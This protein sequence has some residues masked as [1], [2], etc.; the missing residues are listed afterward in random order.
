M[1]W[2][3]LSAAVST[4]LLLTAGAMAPVSAQSPARGTSAAGSA[5]AGPATTVRL[6]TGDRVTVGTGPDGRRTASVEPAP[7]REGIIFKTAEED[8]DLSVLPSDAIGPVSTGKLD[9]RL[10]DVT[11]LLAQGYDEAHTDA[12]PLI[13]SQPAGEPASALDRLSALNEDSA[14]SH[15][16]DSIHA[17]SLRIDGDDLNSFWKQLVPGPDSSTAR[18]AATPKVWLDGRVSPTLDRSTA[19]INAPA[20]WNAGYEGQGVKVAILDT[21]ADLT[22]PDLAGRAATTK[23]FSGSAGTNDAF[24]HGTHVASTVGGSGAASDGRRRGVAPR[25]ELLIGKVL[26]DDGY[27]SESAVIQGMEWAAAEGARVIN[28]SLGSDTPT[29]GTDP[30]SLAVNG[31]SKSS[32]AL[33]VVAAGNSGEQGGE[34]IGSPGAADAALTVGAVDRDDSLAPFSSRGPRLG[35]GAVKPDVTAPG[36]GIVAAR[37]TGTTMGDPVDPYYVAASGTS[38]ATPHVAGAAALL[39]QEHPDW[40]AVRLKDALVSTAHT[41]PGQQVT[42]QGGGRV[43]LAAAALGP[44]TATGTVSLGSYVSG[45]TGGKGQDATIRYTNTSSSEV[46]LRLAARLATTGGQEIADGGVRLGADSVRVAAGATAEVPLHADPSVVARGKYYGYVSATTADGKVAVHT[47]A[48]LTVHG[49]THRLTVNTVD[50]NGKRLQGLPTIWGPDG[51]VNYVSETPAVAEVEEGTY[52]LSY[53]SL[54]NAAD[55]QELREV[56][57]PEVKVTKDMAVTLDARKTT[58]VEIRTPKPAEQRGVLSYQTYRQLDGHGLIQ[59]TMFFDVAKRLYISPTAKVTEG[60]FEFASRWQLVAPLLEAK[61]PGTKISLSPYY[62]HVSPLFGDKGARLSPVDAGTSAAPD[63]RGSRVR[64]K[65]AVVRDE[66]SDETDLAR[67]AARAGAAGLVL[68]FPSDMYSWTRWSPL[69]DRLALPTMRVTAAEGTAL[70]ERAER[71]KTTVEFSGTA[72]SPYLYDVMQVSAGQVPQHVVHTVSDRNSAVVP[73]TYAASGDTGWGSE[74]RFARRPYQDFVWNQYSRYVPTGT[75]RT[76]YVSADDTLWQ[77]FVSDQPAFDVDVPLT[78]GMRD[79]ERT[80]R[81]GKQPGDHWFGAVVRPAI[82]RGST[83]PSVRTGDV[84]ALRIPELTDSGS[85]HWGRALSGGGG[86]GTSATPA[87]E[88]GNAVSARL[89]RNG[90]KTA[91]APDAWAD[92]E[93]A[94][95]K[96]DYRLDLSTSRDAADWTFGT[97][98]ETSWSFRSDTAAGETIL[99]LLQ[100]DYDVPADEHNT[101]TARRGHELGLTVRG[102]DGLS[103]PRGV[104]VQVET[105]YDNG[106]TWT[107]EVRAKD[108]GQNR[109]TTT[110]E[111]P[112]R[113]RGDIYVTLRVTAADSAGNKI[114]QTVERAYLL[115]E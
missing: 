100:L 11:E 24:G 110:V 28:M 45:D 23:D 42:E 55:G 36:V 101:V 25:A 80:Y 78:Q 56:V 76:E 111:R 26:G 44:V 68:I 30:M 19:Q 18:A 81:P 41:V 12:L 108:R 99:P 102:Q 86:I 87:A 37:A 2:T 35:D 74:Q 67:A 92:F 51:F 94:P 57:L 84:L 93:V 72:E 60:Q 29:D 8:G 73:T 85:G 61:V 32:G 115:S 50:H 46:T 64:G 66:G 49:P 90:K 22:H 21:G 34:T 31:L 106:K 103:A 17:R 15:R 82:P 38:M 59:G 112:G 62:T 53:S 69:G 10:F 3:R 14:P 27:G 52:Q 5:Q 47:T 16:L 91:D 97:R 58:Q 9:R 88:Q 113:T 75:R 83:T 95:G 1:R 48:S 33:F 71:H 70:L 6:I 104:T 107:K 63:F 40:D 96:A 98:T 105:S 20:A 4:A 54:D 77:H 39:A 7:G 89:Y 114:R 79:G 65:L 13:V 43:D 109:F